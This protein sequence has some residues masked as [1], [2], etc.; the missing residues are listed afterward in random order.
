MKKPIKWYNDF[1]IYEDR[2]SDVRNWSSKIVKTRKNHTCFNCQT[3][4]KKG[5]EALVEKC[6]DPDYGF[7]SAYT[8]AEC[9]DKWVED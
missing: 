2:D 7:C 1:R 5:S 6:I 4:I 8:C 3:V 9:V